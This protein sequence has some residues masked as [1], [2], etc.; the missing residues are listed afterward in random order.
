MKQSTKQGANN[1]MKHTQ[2]IGRAW[3]PIPSDKITALT[4]AKDY[5][6]RG[7]ALLEHEGLDETNHSHR[8][9]TV[10]LK[11]LKQDIIDLQIKE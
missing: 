7:M 2:R 6:E 1:M 10:G 5:I 4:A 11:L 9:L 3:R 8:R